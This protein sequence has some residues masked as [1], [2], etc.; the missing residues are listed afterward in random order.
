MRYAAILI[1][2]LALAQN[3]LAP[4]E[5]LISAGRYQSAAE[6]LSRHAN[7]SLQWHL[8]AS[9]AYE[10]L[11]DLPRAVSEAEAAL[12]MEPR[13]EAGHLQLGQI[14]LSHNTP[15]AALDI[16]TDAQQLFPKSFLIRLG[17]GLALKEIGRYEEAAG[18]L[19]EC[20]R[21]QPSSRIAFDGLGTAL[22]QSSKFEEL[23]QVSEAYS[24]RNPEDYRGYFY[25][26]AA[27]EGLALSD[28]VSLKLLRKSLQLNPNFAA[29]LSLLGKILLR[30]NSL[31][32]AVAALERSVALRP[33]HVPSH[34]TLATVYRK[35]GREKEAAREFETIRE[36]HEKERQPSPS[37]LYHRGK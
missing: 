30:Q 6:E 14:F 36:I 8:L 35:L 28:D 37:L 19:Q 10:G 34:M 32:E 2:G 11:G 33:D 1:A 22:L 13:S 12:Q 16:F 9:K 15:L 31:Q 26:A 29:S 20:L 4:V 27:R 18:E 7:G 23:V 17:R 24:K 5:R 3:S 25:L 21:Q